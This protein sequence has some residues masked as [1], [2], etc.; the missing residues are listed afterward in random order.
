[1]KVVIR[2]QTGLIDAN[3]DTG[4]QLPDESAIF[5]GGRYGEHVGGLTEVSVN[6]GGAGVAQAKLNYVWDTDFGHVNLAMV[7]GDV[8]LGVLFSDPSNSV[9][10]TNRS[11]IERATSLEMTDMMNSAVSG[12]GLSAFINDSIYIGGAGYISAAAGDIT[13]E[14]GS[15]SHFNPYLR[16]A[17]IAEVGGLEAVLGAFYISSGP[18]LGTGMNAGAGPTPADILAVDATT[19]AKQYGVDLQLQGDVGD[20]SVGF[21]LPYVISSEIVNLGA[22]PIAKQSGGQAMLRVG[23]GHMGINLGYDYT[24]IKPTGLG[25]GVD[26]TEKRPYIGGWYSVAQ[27]VELILAYTNT[28]NSAALNTV[29]QT[30]FV[31]EYVY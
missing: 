8:G 31:V 4:I 15:L 16:A 6:A 22:A 9:R 26:V 18:T 29:S 12:F 13:G 1:M 11:S 21:Y 7:A 28:D 14:W 24:T 5:I 19:S 25:V 2:N 27:N 30:T 23:F 10:H 3:N 17:Y 20:V